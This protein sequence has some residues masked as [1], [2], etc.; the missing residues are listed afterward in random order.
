VSVEKLRGREKG[1]PPPGVARGS[2]V[3]E[4]EVFPGCVEHVK[5]VRAHDD[6]ASTFEYKGARIHPLQV[7]SH[8]CSFGSLN[9]AAFLSTISPIIGQNAE[10]PGD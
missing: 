8:V 5:A 7:M 1:A 3:E 6:L 9:S 2:P 4:D 10:G